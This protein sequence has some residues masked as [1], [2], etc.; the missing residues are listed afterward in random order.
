VPPVLADSQIIAQVLSGRVNLF[1][2]LIVRHQDQVAAIVAGKVPPERTAEVAHEVF[3][4][5]FKSLR[6]F[7]G[8]SPFQHWL[9]SIAVRACRDFWRGQYRNRETPLSALS[10]E[11]QA[12][13]E[14]QDGAA[15]GGQGPNPTDSFETKELIDWALGQLKPDDRLV[16][17]LTYLE[18]KSV[19]ET[20][21]LMG[22]SQA[23]VKIKAMRARG[24][25]RKIIGKALA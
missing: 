3:V 4:R 14:S 8:D 10:Q 18:D 7:R 19:S 15:S 22:I 23:N 16:L 6:N 2:E 9:S 20:A 11:A 12:W 24:K 1:E 13:L 5:S 21:E 25:L 17:T